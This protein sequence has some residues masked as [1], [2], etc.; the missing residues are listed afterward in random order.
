MARHTEHVVH[1]KK[2][3]Y[4]RWIARGS[5]WGNPFRIGDP[6]P[7]TGETMTRQDVLTLHK[8]WIL[9]GEGRRLLGQLGELEGEILGCF[10]A[11]A[12][13]I[14]EH[15]PRVCHGQRLLKLLRWREKK[16]AQKKQR[17]ARAN[18]AGEV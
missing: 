10:C 15:D 8:E 9:R 5:K 13:G 2:D 12:G 7:Q 3:R 14:D 17:A 1:V 16:I 6:H 11:E 18:R 4:T